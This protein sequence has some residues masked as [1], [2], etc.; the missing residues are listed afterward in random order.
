M[1][2]PNKYLVRI[3][4]FDGGP[5]QRTVFAFSAED[6]KF[7]V[8]EELSHCYP[9]RGHVEYVGP[10]NPDCKCLNDCRCGLNVPPQ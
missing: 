10:V 1:E 9:R 7:Q 5:S 6:A 3:Y 4:Y 8:N 2:R